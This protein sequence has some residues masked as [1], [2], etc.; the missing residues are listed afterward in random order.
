MFNVNDSKMPAG[1]A[2]LGWQNLEAA[3]DKL[4]E[5]FRGMVEHDGVSRLQVEVKPLKKGRKNVV[6]SS[7]KDFH[8]V[9][10]PIQAPVEKGNLGSN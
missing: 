2:P 6:L 10:K 4:M 1:P 5:L 7:G 9:L 8:F 3:Q